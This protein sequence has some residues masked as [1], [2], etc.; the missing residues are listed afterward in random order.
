MLARSGSVSGSAGLAYPL[1]W[2]VTETYEFR[3]K[4]VVRGPALIKEITMNDDFDDAR[5]DREMLARYAVPADPD[6]IR[7]TVRDVLNVHADGRA[8][9]RRLRP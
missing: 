4:P 5:T 8:P 7:T 6:R 3:G 1:R 9:H 2:Q